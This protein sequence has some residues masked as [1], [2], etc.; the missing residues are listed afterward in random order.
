MVRSTQ[1]HS[2]LDKCSWLPTG[3]H[4]RDGRELVEKLCFCLSVC[5]SVLS[6]FPSP[7]LRATE[8]FHLSNGQASELHPGPTSK[9]QTPEGSFLP[10]A[11]TPPSPL[12]LPL[13]PMGAGLS[14]FFKKTH[15]HLITFT[16]SVPWATFPSAS[17]IKTTWKSTGQ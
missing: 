7:F 13:S 11:H 3:Q 12:F 16:L 17:G 6:S 2:R 4:S 10:Q 5:L 8:C 14:L 9:K 1:A 15:P